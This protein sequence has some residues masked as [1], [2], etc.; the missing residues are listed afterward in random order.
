MPNHVFIAG[1]GRMKPAGR[2]ITIPGGVT[3]YWAVAPGYNST[4]GLSRALI[5]G[6]AAQWSET[7]NAGESYKEH[8][9][10]PDDAMIMSTKGE[11]LA[12]RVNRGECHL[13]Q[14]KFDFATSLS[15]ILVYLKSQIS[16]PLEVYW[17]CC[18]SPIND[19]S[20]GAYFFEKGQIT[21]KAKS[22]SKIINP[23]EDPKVGGVIKTTK[24]GEVAISRKSIGSDK[25]VSRKTETLDGVTCINCVDGAVT[26]K[27]GS[28][29]GLGL[30][31]TWPAKTVMSGD[32]GLLMTGQ[33]K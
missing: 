33:N 15:S 3:L 9:L 21:P 18:R 6:T 19:A 24:A 11:A 27:R 2:G 13:L 1:H 8:Y 5:S 16:G 12:K 26:L 32:A 20:I 29:G 23:K 14:P 10:C 17:T 28:D 4:G 30:A 7:K 25:Q 31:A 22:G